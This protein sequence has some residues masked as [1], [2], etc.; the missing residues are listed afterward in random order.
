MI[1]K[2]SVAAFVLLDCSA[3]AS[4]A[5]NRIRTQA[6]DPNEI[7]R[8]LGKAG[9][10]STIEFADDERIEN[11][12]VGDSAA[13][14]ITPN[15]RASLLF[16]KPLSAHSRTNMTVVTDHRTYMFDLVAG[17]KSSTPVYALKFSYPHDKA[18]EAAAK[19][20]QQAAATP[21]PAVQATMIAEKLHFDWNTKGNGKLLPSRVFDD[22]ASLYL[23]WTKD[24]PLPAILTQS[25]DRKEGPVNYRLSGEYIVISPIP[26]NLVLRYGK[27]TA[28]LWPSR[29]IVPVQ[30]SAPTAVAS[31]MA[32]AQSVQSQPAVSQAVQAQQAPTAQETSK[33]PSSAVKL[34]NMAALYSD[35]L[36]GTDNEH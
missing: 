22:G 9:I 13:W 21:P 5:D 15:R 20:V 16:V 36:T 28:V 35:K 27:R 19:P 2:V 29:R 12:A 3:A 8:I 30:R 31:R 17:D 23:A 32:T 33:P 34:A 4:A 26:Q 24:T 14:Q 18:A 7:V 11:V 1:R 10:Q 25:E 6:Y